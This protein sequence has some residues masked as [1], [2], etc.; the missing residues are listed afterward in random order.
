[1]FQTRY[2]DD[3]M[4]RKEDAL[5]LVQEGKLGRR[6]TTTSY[7]L[8]EMTG[9]VT[10]QTPVVET[11]AAVDRVMKRGTGQDEAVPADRIY[12]ASSS[13]AAGEQAVAVAGK[14]GLRHP[15][16][17]LLQVPVT[18]VVQVGVRPV[19]VETELAFNTTYQDDA[20]ML[21][22][23]PEVVL[24]E[25]LTGKSVQ[26]TVY[27]LNYQ[28]GQVTAETTEVVMPAVHRLIRR[29]TGQNETLAFK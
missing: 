22:T 28:T 23:D 26:T 11:V 29:G 4:M 9:L 8:D 24:V 14:P 2:E 19:V 18:E 17:S 3:P 7:K 20:S 16:G 15:N 25:G 1:A 10:A 13:L 6:M 12:I 27:T 21:A 5:V